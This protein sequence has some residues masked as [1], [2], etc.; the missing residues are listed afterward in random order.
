MNLKLDP[1]KTTA[2]LVK[3][4]KD[5]PRQTGF[6]KVVVGLS[7]GL[8]SATTLSLAVKA[9]GSKNVLVA[10]LPCGDL[11]KQGLEDALLMI[12][13]LKIPSQSLF[14]IDIQPM[15]DSFLKLFKKANRIRKG[16][17]IARVRMIVLFDLAKKHQALVCGTENKSE[18]LLGYYTRYGDEASDLEPL[19]K[20]YKTQVIQLAAFLG[21]PA[22][23]IDKPPTAGLWPGQ[24]DEKELG[25][26]YQQADQILCLYFEKKYSWQKIFRM[27]LDPKIVKRVKFWVEKNEF[28]KKVPY[29]AKV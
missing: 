15:V 19:R 8:D 4:I 25:V 6:K 26:S 5:K 29:I 22:R 14:K 11:N 21:V 9:L 28:K 12:A 13:R 24:T 18:H 1:E 3:F 10:L 27:E 2:K 16:N 7:G 20:L 17:V 23:I